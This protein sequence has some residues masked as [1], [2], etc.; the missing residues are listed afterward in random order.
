MAWLITCLDYFWDSWRTFAKQMC[1]PP[2]TPI[3]TRYMRKGYE[4]PVSNLTPKKV[5]LLTVLAYPFVGFGWIFYF[6]HVTGKYRVVMVDSMAQAS[7]IESEMRKSIGSAILLSSRFYKAGWIILL[8]S[9]GHATPGCTPLIAAIYFA[10][11]T[12]VRPLGLHRILSKITAWTFCARI[13]LPSFLK[14]RLTQDDDVQDTNDKVLWQTTRSTAA[15]LVWEPTVIRLFLRR[16][17][18]TSFVPAP[19][20]VVGL[21]PPWPHTNCS[22]RDLD[23]AFALGLALA[24]FCVS[25]CSDLLV[26]VK[27]LESV[28]PVRMC[29][30]YIRYISLAFRNGHEAA[31]R[32]WILRGW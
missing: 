23:Q 29:L 3:T 9:F 4:N 20:L 13:R 19:E 32:A 11:S 16:F 1:G 15:M 12:L 8:A 6:E 31:T 25:R 7:V 28:K 5:Q 17:L 27:T 18:R 26:V 14:Q 10:I 21:G 30:E 24:W 2:E 22:L